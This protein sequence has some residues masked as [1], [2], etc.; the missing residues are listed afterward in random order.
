MIKDSTYLIPWTV[1]ILKYETAQTRLQMFVAHSFMTLSLIRPFHSLKSAFLTFVILSLLR[2]DWH[3][4]LGI[5]HKISTWGRRHA[6]EVLSHRILCRCT[7]HL[8]RQPFS[9]H[10]FTPQGMQLVMELRERFAGRE[11]FTLS[12]RAFLRPDLGVFMHSERLQGFW[13]HF[14]VCLPPQ[15]HRRQFWSFTT[16]WVEPRATSCWTNLRWKVSWS[17]WHL[18]SS[19]GLVSCQMTKTLTVQT[20]NNQWPIGL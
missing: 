17:R 14:P 15:A 10:R 19:L 8:W 4:F 6:I 20:S 2:Q 9:I 18:T 13:T 7:Y 12:S 5:P 16:S 11:S 1:E 3:L